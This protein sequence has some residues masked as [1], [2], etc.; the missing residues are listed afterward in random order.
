MI[1]FTIEHTKGRENVLADTL[2]RIPL[3]NSGKAPEEELD[4][5]LTIDPDVFGSGSEDNGRTRRKLIEI[6]IMDR[7][8]PSMIPSI[9]AVNSTEGQTGDFQ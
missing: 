4:Q 1:I 3:P 8:Q 6:T 5:M 2:S 7:Q 9:S